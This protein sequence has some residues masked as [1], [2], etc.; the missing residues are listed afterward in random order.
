MF[1][2]CTGHMPRGASKMIFSPVPYLIS[3]YLVKMK[4]W[5]LKMNYKI[6]NKFMPG[7][8]VVTHFISFFELFL[9]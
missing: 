5:G 6:I 1:F 7:M 9:I 4:M 3:T 8:K 2:Y